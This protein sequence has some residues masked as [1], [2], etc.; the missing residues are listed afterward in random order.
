MMISL[1]KRFFLTSLL[2]LFTFYV[3]ASPV[4]F[5]IDITNRDSYQIGTS[6]G[7]AI[8]KRFPQFQ[9][10]Y[11][12]YLAFLF[13]Q[14]HFDQLNTQINSLKSA[15]KADYQTEVDA[16]AST[17]H[18]GTVD[19]LGDGQLSNN[20]FWLLQLL[21][22]LTAI[23]KGSALGLVSHADKNPLVARNVDWKNTPE[24][25]SLQAITIYRDSEYTLVNI[26]F[27]G[28]VGIINGFNDQGL[29]ASVMDA[30]EQQSSMSSLYRTSTSFAVREALEKTV[31]I[32]AASHLLAQQ[33]YPRGH[34]IVL[35]DQE[36]IAVLEQPAGETGKLRKIDSQL[37]NELP[38]SNPNQFAIVNCFALKTSP[39]NCYSTTDH[40]RWQRFNNLLS[41]LNYKN[42]IIT[43]TELIHLMQDSANPHQAIFNSNTLQLMA[44]N[45]K[46]RD[47]YLYTKPVKETHGSQ[48]LV[49]KFQFI[50]SDQNTLSK[51]LHLDDLMLIFGVFILIAAWIYVFWGRDVWNKK[52][53][54]RLK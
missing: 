28:L 6:L 21:A 38:W 33:H 17:L 54:K 53:Q 35:A 34:Q 15:L 14:A 52:I 40:Y 4:V 27:A 18:L 51:Q 44:F 24:L 32:S 37:I 25:R 1:L 10:L 9:Q 26:G 47:L 46:N 45:P 29:W 11:D 20:E 48:P 22:D 49:E 43:L 31:K 41:S 7:L 5:T 2:F 12:S 8:Q 19:Q 13:S 3:Y 39:Q 36:D 23:N 16:I 42:Q 30:S 50:H